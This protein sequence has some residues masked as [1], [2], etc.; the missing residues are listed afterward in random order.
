MTPE[1]LAALKAA[2]PSWMDGRGLF[3][4]LP[5][6]EFPPAGGAI[7]TPRNSPQAPFPFLDPNPP[8]P[9]PASNPTCGGAN[10]FSSVTIVISGWS[11]GGPGGVPYDI[12]G[13]YSVPFV[14]LDP[15]SGCT[16]TYVDPSGNFILSLGC[17]PA[18]GGNPA[19]LQITV[20]DTSGFTPGDIFNSYPPWEND[21]SATFTNPFSSGFGGGVA[22]VSQ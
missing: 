4:T 13:S 2:A 19:L 15:G 10:A 17:S 7:I 3:P 11:A 9:P 12:N 22:T 18:S 16:W 14:L 1:D 6:R 21:I 20:Q 5:N 8:P